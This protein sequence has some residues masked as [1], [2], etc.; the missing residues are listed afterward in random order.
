MILQ[1]ITFQWLLIVFITVAKECKSLRIGRGR[2][3]QQEGD[4]KQENRKEEKSSDEDGKTEKKAEDEVEEAERETV[5]EKKIELKN[6]DCIV[7][8]GE[9]EEDVRV[10]FIG[11]WEKICHNI[12]I[13]FCFHHDI[14]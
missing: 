7:E 12:V 14:V 11:I 8:G 13:Y 1:D 2:R 3:R 9:I 6:E 5:E 10:S 4:E